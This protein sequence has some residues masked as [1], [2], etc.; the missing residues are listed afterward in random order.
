M[1]TIKNIETMKYKLVKNT[2]KNFPFLSK[3]CLRNFLYKYTESIKQ[4]ITNTNENNKYNIAKPPNPL[5][6]KFQII[7]NIIV[8]YLLM[9]RKYLV[10]QQL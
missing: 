5:P 10:N 4:A 9:L 6:D 2:L 3:Y 1:M 8:I 7:I